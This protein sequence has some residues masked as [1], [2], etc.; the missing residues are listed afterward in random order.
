MGY[1]IECDW[2]GARL[3]DGDYAELPVTIKRRRSNALD[4]RWAEE[5]KPTRF[6]CVAPEPDR[7]GRNRMGLQPAEEETSDSCYERALRTIKGT[8]ASTPDMGMEWRLV[9]IG[10]AIKEAKPKA[11]VVLE[12]DLREFLRTLAP[13]CRRALPC[14]GIKSFAQVEAM[15]DEE[16]LCVDGV[17]WATLRRLREFLEARNG[18]LEEHL[19]VKPVKEAI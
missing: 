2:C 6:F 11:P 8:K 13:K 1:Y 3:H 4:G 16:L 18:R 12:D 10:A 17:G 15:S 9:P 14:A 19:A 5:T 7:E